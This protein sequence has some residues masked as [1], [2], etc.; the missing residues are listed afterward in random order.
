MLNIRLAEEKDLREILDI[1]NQAVE[2]T[3]A[4]FDTEPRQW[5][6]Q[7]AWFS[8][9]G[10]KHPVLVAGFE[11][12]VLGWA[13]LSQWSDRPAYD[14]TAEVSLYVEQNQRGKGVGKALLSAILEEGKKAG[15]HTVIA[16]ITEGN[17]ASIYL[18]EKEGFQMIGTMKE[19]G[20]KFGK[21]LDVHM[22]QK[23]YTH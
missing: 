15:L 13:S 17:A 7:L 18:H 14:G 10:P 20:V 11:G 6:Q 2:T 22:L 16:R 4:T 5:E 19:V 21:L 3:N 8:K 12:T 23:I 9:H 1:Y